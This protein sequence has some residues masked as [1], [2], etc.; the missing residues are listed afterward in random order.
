[1]LNRIL[2]ALFCPHREPTH[3]AN[4]LAYLRRL[5]RG[6]KLGHYSADID[7]TRPMGYR[8]TVDGR[9]FVHDPY[10]PR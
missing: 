6:Q 9:T 10:L 3:Q 7:Y 8:V 2:R 1:M 5:A 4:K